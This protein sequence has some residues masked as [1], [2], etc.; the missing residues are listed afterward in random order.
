MNMQ[1]GVY[2]YLKTVGAG[3]LA[4]TLPKRPNKLK[5]ANKV[6]TKKQVN[7][8]ER[9]GVVGHRLHQHELETCNYCG[10]SILF[11]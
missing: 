7:I 1:N 3:V 8:I 4:A 11:V 10:H 5:H 2:F 9:T 6:K